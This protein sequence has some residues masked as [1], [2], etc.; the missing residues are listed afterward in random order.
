MKALLPTRE[1]PG[2]QL[3]KQQVE[4]TQPKKQ[5]RKNGGSNQGST[6]KADVPPQR[7]E[8]ETTAEEAAG[9]NEEQP[10]S[11]EEAPMTQLGERAKNDSRGGK[12]TR[13]WEQEGEYERVRIRE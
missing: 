11:T 4:G 5:A 8:E 10:G 13:Q 7:T 12:R 6:E 3:K 9:K 1:Q 2:T